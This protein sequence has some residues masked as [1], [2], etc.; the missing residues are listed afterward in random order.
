M[1]KFLFGILFI[2]I[3]C[4]TI[5]LTAKL[6][7]CPPNQTIYKYIPRTFAEEQSEPVWVSDIFQTM[8]TLQ[9]PWVKSVNDI[10][11]RQAEKVN[12]YYISQY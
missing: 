3:I 4:I 8:F 5:N 12:A 7:S 2:G 9:S 11:V 6:T 1:K 10:D